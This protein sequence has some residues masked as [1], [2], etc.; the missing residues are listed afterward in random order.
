MTNIKKSTT[1]STV[2]TPDL[3]QAHVIMAAFDM[4]VSGQPSFYVKQWYNSTI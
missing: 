2:Q 1:P 3:R 4:I